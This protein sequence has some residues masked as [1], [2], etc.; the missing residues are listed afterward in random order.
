MRM[1]IA[2]VLDRLSILILKCERLRPGVDEYL[3]EFFTYA[4]EILLEEDR[5][6]LPFLLDVLE[7]LYIINGKIWDLESDIRSEREAELGLEEVGRRAIY[8]RKINKQRIEIKNEIARTVG[9][10]VE[11]RKNH[12]SA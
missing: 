8:I 10:P 9:E 11:T 1:P 5:D 7:S 2:E 3:N 4:R 6:S 12:G